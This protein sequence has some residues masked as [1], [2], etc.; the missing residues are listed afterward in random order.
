MPRLRGLRLGIPSPGATL[1][2]YYLHLVHLD[3]RT[4]LDPFIAFVMELP[5]PLASSLLL[6]LGS[7]ATNRPSPPQS[8]AH[9][10]QA[11]KCIQYSG[12]LSGLATFSTHSGVPPK[13]PRPS[14]QPSH[15]VLSD[16]SDKHTPLQQLQQPKPTEPFGETTSEVPFEDPTS[17]PLRRFPHS[18]PL[19]RRCP[20]TRDWF[21]RLPEH[22]SAGLLLRL[23]V[24]D[25]HAVVGLIESR[26]PA[27][28]ATGFVTT[29]FAT[30]IP[31]VIR[32]HAR[33]LR[34]SCFIV[35]ESSHRTLLFGGDCRI[36]IYSEPVFGQISPY[37]EGTLR[38]DPSHWTPK[39]PFG[40]TLR[41]VHFGSVG[42]CSDC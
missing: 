20:E 4:D 10:R 14:V 25:C 26:A 40:D 8:P 33:A 35:S 12:D 42:L 21:R 22:P 23:P 16:L 13:V 5:A 1:R 38:Q 29:G 9:H 41:T 31:H 11:D 3:P 27:R 6:D 30:F 32:S 7:P 28:F 34:S 39:V 15:R 17:E 19:R 36:K 2:T 37:A 18:E 24:P